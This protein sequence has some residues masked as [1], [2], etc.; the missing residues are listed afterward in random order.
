MTQKHMIYLSSPYTAKGPQNT[1]TE[2]REA[3]WLQAWRHQQAVNATSALIASGYLVF[4]PIVYSVPL[5]ERGGMGTAWSDWAE[6]DKEF[7]S[8]CQA[9]AILK[10]LGWRESTGV[11]A[12][13]LHA[14]GLRL[15]LLEVDPD[16]FELRPLRKE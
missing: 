10:I 4:S 15:K 2:R 9:F 16:I 1:E 13:L 3:A 5:V 6:Y 12:E 8:H 14:I 11:N 7:I